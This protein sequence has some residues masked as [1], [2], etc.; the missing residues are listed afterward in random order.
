M[1]SGRMDVITDSDGYIL[2]DRSG[3]HFE[4]ILNY[5]RDEDLTDLNIYLDAK[6]EPELY[7]ILKECKF[8]CIQP[9]VMLI[10]QKLNQK[11]ANFQEPYLGV[12]IVSMITSKYDLSRILSST[13]KPCIH[14][15]IN[16]HNN[17]YSYT[18]TSDDNLLKNIELFERMAI[19][20]K[21][22]I[23][24]IKDTTSNEEVR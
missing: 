18:N 4:F 20:F 5:L 13:D 24:F 9:V 19:K 12:S 17:K 2:I 7:E 16:R 21:N 1:F 6:S 23:I 8:Y 22:R 3:K 10:E 11:L 15:L 14:L